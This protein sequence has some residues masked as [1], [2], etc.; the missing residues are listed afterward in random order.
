M[1]RSLVMTIA[2]VVLAS[3]AD[4]TTT[5]LGLRHGA[6][7][8]GPLLALLPL[9]ALVA[10]KLAATVILV[11]GLGLL[12]ARPRLARSCA[13]VIAALFALATANNVFWLAV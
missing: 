8:A 5:L 12:R 3:L 11:L 2:L 1:S 7:E 9:P 4:L 6:V 13:L 10:F